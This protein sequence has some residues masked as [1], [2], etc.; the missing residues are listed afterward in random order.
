MNLGGTPQG[1][2]GMV[3]DGRTLYI[4]ER[5]QNGDRIVRIDMAVDLASGTIRDN[6]RDDSFGFPTTIAKLD[7]RMLVVNSQFNNRGGT[8]NLP[9]TVSDIPIPR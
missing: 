3:L 2:D 6:F 1:G 4:C 5:I 9:F 8:P 7:S